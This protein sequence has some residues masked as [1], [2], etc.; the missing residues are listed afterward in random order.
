MSSQEVYQ[1]QY[2]YYNCYKLHS[3]MVHFNLT[4]EHSKITHETCSNI[5]LKIKSHVE[6]LGKCDKNLKSVQFVL[7]LMD[8]ART[9]NSQWHSFWLFC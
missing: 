9:S 4:I 3:L 7:V 2:Y 5:H 1:H 6:V 8:K